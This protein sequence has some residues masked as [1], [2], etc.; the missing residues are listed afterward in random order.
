MKNTNIETDL[1]YN[2]PKYQKAMI[3]YLILIFDFFWLGEGGLGVEPVR[4]GVVSLVLYIVNT[5]CFSV[6]CIL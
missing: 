5:V 2:D 4:N 3:F 6:F 1:L